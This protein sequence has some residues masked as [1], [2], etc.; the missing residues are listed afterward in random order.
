M[1]YPVTINPQTADLDT[2]APNRVT[3]T[4][5]LRKVVR[6]S[7]VHRWKLRLGYSRLTQEQ[8]DEIFAFVVSQSGQYGTFDMPLSVLGRETP[9]GLYEV[10]KDIPIIDGA[11]S[12]LDKTIATKGWRTGGTAFRY[13][14]LEVTDTN[15]ASNNV[16]IN[17]LEIYGR[18]TAYPASDMTSDTLP[19]PLVASASSGSN[20]FNAFDG[21]NA[22]GWAAT[23][24]SNE[25]IQ[26]DLGTGQGIVPTALKIVPDDASLTSPKNFALKGSNTGAFSGEETT[27]YTGT[28]VTS[29]WTAETAREFPITTGA[30]NA[31]MKTGAFIQFAGDNKLY[32]LT[33]DVDVD[34]DGKATINIFP[35]LVEARTGDELITTSGCSLKSSLLTDTQKIKISVPV[36]GTTS[37]EFIEDL[38]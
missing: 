9:L 36:V 12:V 37:V 4:H 3:V 20:P 30:A 31:V 28:N 27:L 29:G 38:N 25:Y 34:S 2:Y 1:P 22:A 21:N 32:M 18:A 10:A 19:S 17:E 14:R 13:F 35:G 23:S 8:V 26:I 5:N 7:G 16:T 11:H 33:E 6:S 15:T 24:D